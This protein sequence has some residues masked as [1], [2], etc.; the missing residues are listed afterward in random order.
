MHMVKCSELQSSKIYPSGQLNLHIFAY[1]NRSSWTVYLEND[2]DEVG[3][4]QLLKA[5]TF[6]HPNEVS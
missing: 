3:R 2:F 6:L 4:K 5:L 1:F